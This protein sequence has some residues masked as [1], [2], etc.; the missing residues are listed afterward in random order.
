MS[1]AAPVHRL[2]VDGL[3][4]PPRRNGELVFTE[5]WQSRAFG[6]VMALCDGG[7]LGW[8][9][10]RQ[11]LIAR[12]GATESERAG[13]KPEDYWRCWLG[14]LEGVAGRHGLVAAAEVDGRAGWLA[15]VASE[16]GH[17]GHPHGG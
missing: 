7:R 9:E 14:A 12:V 8:E 16:G 10:F 3:A 6:M 15:A 13:W 17:H 1:D 5:P 11:E 4:A 2:D